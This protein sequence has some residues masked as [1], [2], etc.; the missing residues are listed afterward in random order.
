[1]V[2]MVPLK[3]SNSSIWGGEHSLRQINNARRGGRLSPSHVIN[4][5][6]AAGVFPHRM[7]LTPAPPRASFPIAIYGEGVA[8]R[9][10]VRSF[11]ALAFEPL[12][13]A[14]VGLFLVVANAD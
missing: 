11:P 12:D 13:R 8:D 1:M 2:T 14:I 5:R 9:P 7:S 4:A 6:A 10:G 3:L